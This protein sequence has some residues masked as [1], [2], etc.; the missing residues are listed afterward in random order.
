ML[1][2]AALWYK[3]LDESNRQKPEWFVT[4]CGNV[5]R[6]VARLTRKRYYSLVSRTLFDNGSHALLLA[7]RVSGRGA[8][9]NS[10]KHPHEDT[11]MPQNGIFKINA[12]G[13]PERWANQEV[14]YQQGTTV[15]EVISMGHAENETA[16]VRAFY[17]QYNI[18]Q[19]AKIKAK[20]AEEG[21][22]VEQLSEI[23]QNGK[24]LAEK[25]AGGGKGNPEALKAAAEARKANKEKAAS[26][27]AI[28]KAAA[29]DPAIQKQLDKL[30]AMGVKI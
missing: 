6:R 22:T 28:A 1:G 12:K 13:Y 8:I 2:S 4:G 16:L 21:S 30:R 29:E 14:P 3:V 26:F 9:P 25:Q 7:R 23:L 20:A 11:T 10:G 27:D 17:G 18:R 5:A 19:S 24:L 15:A